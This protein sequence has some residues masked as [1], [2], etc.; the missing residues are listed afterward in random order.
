MSSY[1][2]WRVH[3]TTEGADKFWILGEDEATPTTCPTNTAHTIDSGKTAIL[4]TISEVIIK[5]K[6]ESQETGG[7]FQATTMDFN[8]PPNTT[9]SSSLSFPHPISALS[10]EFVTLDKHK[11]DI[12]NGS[13]GKDT[14]IGNIMANVEP[15]VG[16]TGINYSVGDVV[17]YQHPVFGER[18]YTCILDTVSNEVPTNETYWR[19]GFEV[20]VSASVIQ[21][22]MVGYHLKLDDLTNNDYMCR[23]LHVD[24]INNKVYLELNCSNSYSMFSPTYVK[25][26][27]YIVYNYKIGEPWEHEIGASKIGGSYIP[28]DIFITVDYTN[29]STGIDKTVTGHIEYLY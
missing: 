24:K 26:T 13:V 22:T 20:T 15:A 6:E 16:W 17:T 29:G 10:L 2:R 12:L 5:I 4:N 3:C 19:H 7:N 1:Y 18:V 27:V 14:I 23:V 9:T 28:K 11:G 8:A 25:Q 21:Y